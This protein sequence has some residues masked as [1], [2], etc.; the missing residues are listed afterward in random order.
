[1]IAADAERTD[2]RLDEAMIELFDVLM[3]AREIIAALHGNVADIGD[4]RH[5]HRRDL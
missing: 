2:A 4:L 3:A 1:M 5:G